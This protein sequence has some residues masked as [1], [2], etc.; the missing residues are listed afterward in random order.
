MQPLRSFLWNLFAFVMVLGVATEARATTLVRADLEQLVATNKSIAIGE[1][2]EVRSYWNAERTFMLTDV[3][4]SV[5]E[6][7]KGNP[8]EKEFTITVMGGTIG[9]F[10]TVIVG[11]AELAQG[12][13]YLLFLDE[14]DLPGA[15]KVRTVREHSQGVFELV[16]TESGVRAISQAV[17]H[18]L[19]P[20]ARGIAEPPG[21]AQGLPLK[22]L[23]QTIREFVARGTNR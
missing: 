19:V 16:K 7:L 2:R 23:T 14:S 15:K 3:R 11:G 20:D 8:R 22:E 1:V 18:P 17:R 9:Q 10:S 12:Q 5:T 6:L 13:S 21:G 4:F